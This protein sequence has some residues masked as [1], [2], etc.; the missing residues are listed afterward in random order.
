MYGES[1]SPGRDSSKSA[2]DSDWLV[3]TQTEKP[4]GVGSGRE[5][6]KRELV[7]DETLGFENWPKL[8]TPISDELN[9]EVPHPQQSHEDR[10]SEQANARSL[11]TMFL[12]LSVYI[13]CSATRVWHQI[14]IITGKH[15]IACKL[16]ILDKIT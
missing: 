7:G 10:T 9:E 8:T 16:L 4:L 15:M 11:L 13:V 14:E 1:Q 5:N 2:T 12:F 3:E 6:R